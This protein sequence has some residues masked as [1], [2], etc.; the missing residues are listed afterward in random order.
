MS[1]SESQGAADEERRWYLDWTMGSEERLI[2]VYSGGSDGLGVEL[3]LQTG[4]EW[5]TDSA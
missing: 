1:K 3:H 5:A 4:Q 2:L